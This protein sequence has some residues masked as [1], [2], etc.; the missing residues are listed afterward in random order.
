MRAAHR[1]ISSA[2]TY[3]QAHLVAW[4]AS[5]AVGVK[6]VNVEHV[7]GTLDAEMME[8]TGDFQEQKV[9]LNQRREGKCH[10]DRGEL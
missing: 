4:P 6:L 7:D 8:L 3:Q 5:Q 2:V 10:C 1:V 9:V